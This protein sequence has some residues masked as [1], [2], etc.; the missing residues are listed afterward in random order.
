MW[1]TSILGLGRRAARASRRA[2]ADLRAR[3]CTKASS[4]GS[5]VQTARLGGE[6]EEGGGSLLSQLRSHLGPLVVWTAVS[7]QVGTF[8]SQGDEGVQVL[9]HLDEFT[10]AVLSP[11]T[12]KS[13]LTERLDRISRGT[14][15]NNSL[16][17]ALL[18][19]PGLVARLVSFAQDTPTTLG[20]TAQNHA[21]KILENVSSLPE[22]QAAALSVSA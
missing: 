11:S 15:L 22:A 5:F 8:F 3:I 4:E 21:A 12:A 20:V 19:T 2:S 17:L 1:R 18:D 6:A 14:A 10:S 7:I 9:I 13:K 16:R